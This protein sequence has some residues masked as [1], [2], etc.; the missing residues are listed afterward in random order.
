MTK[1]CVLCNAEIEGKG[2]NP[3][4]IREHGDGKCCDWC[5]SNLVAPL[6]VQRHLVELE[7]KSRA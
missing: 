6:R 5:N 4:P 2:H 7:K 3:W 1:E